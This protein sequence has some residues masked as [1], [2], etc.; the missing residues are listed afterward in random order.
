MQASL[1]SIISCYQKI[2]NVG[3]LNLSKALKEKSKLKFIDYLIE[4]K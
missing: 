2:L 1:N 3:P 4:Q